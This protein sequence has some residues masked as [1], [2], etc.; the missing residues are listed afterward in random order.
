MSELAEKV[1]ELGSAKSQAGDIDV[2]GTVGGDVK[3]QAGDI[4]YRK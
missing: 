2:G 4:K 1:K 3:T